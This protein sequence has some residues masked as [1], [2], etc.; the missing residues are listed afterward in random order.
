VAHL[1]VNYVSAL[2]FKRQLIVLA[3]FFNYYVTVNP[4]TGRQCF[5]YNITKVCWG[6]LKEKSF[7]KDFCLLIIIICGQ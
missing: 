3:I 6:Q 2:L 7:Y 5:I 4:Q 1:L